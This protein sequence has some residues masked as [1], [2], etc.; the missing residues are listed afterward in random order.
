MTSQTNNDQTIKFFAQNNYFGLQ[1]ADV[2]FLIQEM[3]PA[4]NRQGKMILDAK[5]HLFMNPN[6]HGGSLKALWDSSAISD[7]Q[8]RSIE[9]IFYFQVDNVL[10]K[11]C[12]PVYIGYHVSGGSEM[13]NK[14]VRKLSAEEK[15]GILCMINNRLGLVEYSDLSDEDM[16]A[17]DENGDLKFWAGNIA[18]HILEA[19]FVIRENDGGFHL[20]YHIAEKS[21]PYV[22]SEGSLIRPDEKNG[23]K[24]ETFVFDALPDATRS[25][26]IEVDRAK[27]FSALKN[28]EGTN[29]PLTVKNDLTQTYAGWLEKA[30]HTLRKDQHGRI[31]QN[32][33]ISPVLAQDAADL[34][35]KDYKFDTEADDIYLE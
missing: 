6:G 16:H 26:S 31:L 2:F 29:S 10:T 23:L 15:M 12:D 14:V 4:I 22:D 33:E 20:P 25:V 3:V 17:T 5:D 32:I 9:T 34:S 30:G 8:N 35:A 1:K 19:A 13:S 28:K 27:E 18:T 11:I 24:F 7:M 21:I